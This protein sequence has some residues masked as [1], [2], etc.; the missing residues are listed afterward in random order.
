MEPP[1]N[2][3][4][5]VINNSGR[6]LKLQTIR[7]AVAIAL[8]RHGRDSGLV[9]VLLTG[10]EEIQSLN[11]RF[12]S[13]DEPTDVLSF[14]GDDFPNAPLGD[15]AISVEYAERQAAARHVSLAQELAYLSIHGALHLAG[16][17]DETEPDRAA[18]VGE[19][20]AVAIEAGLKPD[21]EWHSLLHAGANP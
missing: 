18:M 4:V 21:L 13:V 7:Q 14:P 2:T 12:R 19:M 8:A 11:R 20:N 17:N 15:I 3:A 5:T 6:R 16:L 1:S 9:N 10:D